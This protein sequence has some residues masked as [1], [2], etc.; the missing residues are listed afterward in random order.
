MTLEEAKEKCKM[1]EELSLGIW[2]ADKPNTKAELRSMFC[3]CYKS[4]VSD[5]Y[6]VL[7]Y[8][9][10]DPKLGYKVPKFKVREDNSK[11]MVKIIDNRGNGYHKGDCTTRCISFCT[12]VD[13]ETI[14]KEQFENARLYGNRW[15]TISVWSKSL[16]S[17]GFCEI[18]LPKHVS[19][20]VFLRKF[21]KSGIDEGIIATQSSGHL[22]AIDM[23]T[24]KILDL[25]NSAG[26]RI[27]RIYVPGTMKDIWTKKIN[28]ILG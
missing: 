10:L 27:K 15:R 13:Y 4:I 26:G 19:R 2:N 9:E 23:K 22:A 25:F 17:R 24:K 20:K 14:Q 28:A 3:D 12:G 6:K 16:T 21:E 5:G 7:P 11:D 8:K 18:V 1:L